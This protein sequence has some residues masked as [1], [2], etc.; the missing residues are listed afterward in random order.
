M[1][2]INEPH[3]TFGIENVMY[4]SYS[5]FGK[6]LSLNGVLG[7][8]WPLFDPTEDDTGLALLSGGQKIS[9]RDGCDDARCVLESLVFV[10]EDS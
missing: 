4:N 1:Y 10:N 5:G 6:S 8:D 7:V 2:Y 3:A 9:G